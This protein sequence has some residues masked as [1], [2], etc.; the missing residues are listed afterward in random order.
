M[1]I[2]IVNNS[3]SSGS[4]PFLSSNLSKLISQSETTVASL[5]ALK[6]F[7]HSMNGGIGLLQGAIDSIDE[8]IGQEE[9]KKSDLVNA[10]TKINGFIELVSTTD[11]EVSNKVTQNRNEFY[12][13]NEWSRPSSL[14]VTLESWYN[15]AKTWL[16]GALKE[17]SDAIGHVWNVYTE[18]DY[19]SLSD[20]EL[21]KLCN[22]YV[23]MLKSGELSTDDRTRLQ[24]LLNYLGNVE[25]TSN[26]S[27]SDRNKVELFNLV[28]EKMQGHEDEAEKMNAFF[29]RSSAPFG[30]TD[31]E[32]SDIK[33]LSYKS[34]EP[35]HTLLFSYIDEVRVEDFNGSN[36][37]WYLGMNDDSNGCG[38]HIGKGTI[39]LGRDHDWDTFGKYHSFFEE[40]GHAID[41]AIVNGMDDQLFSESNL[42]ALNAAIQSDVTDGIQMVKEEIVVNKVHMQLE[43]HACSEFCDEEKIVSVILGQSS[44]IT[45]NTFELLILANSV[46]CIK[47][48]KTCYNT[49]YDT[50][51]A[52]LGKD[53]GHEWSGEYDKEL[54]Y[55]ELF[56][57]YIANGVTS[58]TEEKISREYLPKTYAVLDEMVAEHLKSM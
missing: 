53:W 25:I 20:E 5:Y 30:F 48:N 39:S 35:Y 51:G 17:A 42:N 1:R 43:S 56:S 46:E 44:G 58:S 13:V 23:E 57:E 10:Q 4:L 7:S 14:S 15:N 50:Y 38:Y 21:R 22:K 37:A 16:S 36:P 40:V 47:N 54:M 34:D 49:A 2:E 19:S 24:S 31:D 3:N 41:D 9:T 11:K 28:Y 45:L 33:Y 29:D 8:R 6:N 26:M 12:G 32:I 18:T 55:T 52:Y 27:E